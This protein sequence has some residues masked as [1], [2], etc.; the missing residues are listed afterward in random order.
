MRWK[1]LLVGFMTVWSLL[2]CGDQTEER[3]KPVEGQ[4]SQEKD[5]SDSCGFRFSKDIS[6]SQLQAYS[7]QSIQD[8]NPLVLCGWS[9]RVS[10]A[11]IPRSGL[12]GQTFLKRFQNR[13]SGVISLPAICTLSKF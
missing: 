2:G 10:M 9:S 12:C 13:S 7:T 5:G 3:S 1:S 11:E 8:G 6:V 4:Q